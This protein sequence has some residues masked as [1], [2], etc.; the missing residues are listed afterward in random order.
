MKEKEFKTSGN[1]CPICNYDLGFKA[2]DNGLGSQEICPSCGVQYGYSDSVGDSLE[3][4][5]KLYG[6]WYK[7]WINNNKKPLS[8]DQI[9]KVISIVIK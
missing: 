3:K 7:A 4:R 9:K 6:L 8:I 2:W 5:I 1:L